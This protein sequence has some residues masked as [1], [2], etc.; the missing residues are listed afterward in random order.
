MVASIKIKIIIAAVLA[1]L[2]A[3]GGGGLYIKY[4]WAE[5]KRATQ[6]EAVARA[7][8][9]WQRR[10][11]AGLRLALADNYK[12]MIA[13]EQKLNELADQT[14]H[15]RHELEELYVNSEPCGLWADSPVPGPVLDRLRP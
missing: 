12:A 1:V 15:L 10:E 6:G 14:E 5:N 11:A 13:R 8:A 4:L 3:G 9:D 2:L 7:E